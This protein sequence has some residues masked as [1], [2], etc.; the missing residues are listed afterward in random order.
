VLNT[1][2][3]PGGSVSTEDVRKVRAAK[4]GAPT[5]AEH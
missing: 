5:A 4:G 2:D 1:W 3:N